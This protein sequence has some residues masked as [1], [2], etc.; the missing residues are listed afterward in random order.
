[1]KE[2][3]VILL[4]DDQQQNNELLEALL[5]PQGYEIVMAASG[6]EALEKLSAHQIDLILL[7][8]MMPG[9]NGF[10]VTRRIRGDHTHQQLPIVLV[11]VLTDTD[12]RVKGIEAGCDDFIIKPID[13]TELLA[14]VRSLL[15]V[16]AYNDLMSNYRKELEFEVARRTE[17]LRNAFLFQQ[18]L[19]DALSVP[20][21]YK[22]LEGNFVGC[23]SSFEKFFG[24]KRELL[25]G[26]STFELSQKETADISNEKDRIL[27]QNS[28]I[29]IFESVLKDADG[30]VR[31]VIF[32]KATYNN[33]DGSIGGL[34]GAI[35]DITDLKTAEKKQKDLESQLHQ[36]QKMESIG[37]LAGG[38]AHDF[39]N[40]LSAILGFTELALTAV[41]KG[42]PVEA[43]LHEVYRAGIRA[44]DLVTQILAIARQSDDQ[45]K[46]I[47]VDIIIKEVLKF[48]RS[49]IPTTIEIKQNLTSESSIMGSPSQIHQ[50]IM[51]LCANAAHA[52]GNDGGILEITLKDITIDKNTNKIRPKLKFE[53][54]IELKISDTGVGIKPHI[55]EKIFEPY[56][57]TKKIGEG[58]G[59]GLALAYGI[60]EKYGGEM[61][62]ESTLGEGTVF[63]MYLPITKEES[64]PLAYKSSEAPIGQ[65]RIMFVDDE[66][67]IVKI[68]S[69]ML[70]QLGYFVTTKTSSVEA[71][72]AFRAKPNDFDLVI[73]DMTMP[74]MTGD[75]LIKKIREIR[76]DIP[77]ILCTGYSK[78]LTDGKALE[79]D[80]QAFIKKPIIKDYLAKTV[81]NVLDLAKD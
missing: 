56:F 35:L 9:M 80:I 48:I 69:R 22:D 37:T 59:M 7:D 42:T 68:M 64:A 54:Y 26:K 52:M 32:H 46:P 5:V 16:K 19:I 60:V 71:L 67:P 49:S 79:I 70:G 66:A 29:Q 21:F 8:V 62:V 17:D 3:P 6:E 40:I 33:L 12:A 77:V 27:L 28:G 13:K 61:I 65:E 31:N 72:E 20:V 45:L 76:P 50:I 18:N 14:R 34:I 74:Q 23:N 63:T 10:E 38:I 81:R 36:A 25:I 2:K 47:Q 1:M 58:T 75:L 57:T 11:T 15:K 4:V 73:S 53:N 78:K 41:E 55:I 24:Q 43:D 30:V 51:N 39:N 44:K